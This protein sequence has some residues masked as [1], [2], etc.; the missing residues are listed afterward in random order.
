[1][2]SPFVIFDRDGTLIEHVHHL[3]LPEQ[4]VLKKD[5]VQS[6]ERLFKMEI[7]FGIVTN[8]SVVGRGLSSHQEVASVHEHINKAIE[9]F[10]LKFS[11]LKY[12]PHLQSDHCACRKPKTLLGEQIIEE[13]DLLPT[14]G[15]VIGDSFSDVEFGKNLG[16]KTILLSPQPCNSSGADFNCDSLL[17]AVAYII[18]DVEMRPFAY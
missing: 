8:Q 5:L 7:L 14:E 4:V 12:C 1:M 17:S 2:G 11:F 10:G 13:L 6:L 15:F 3:T 16:C 9:G 18:E